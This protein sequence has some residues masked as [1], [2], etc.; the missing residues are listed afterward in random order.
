MSLGELQKHDPL[1]VVK[2]VGTSEVSHTF[3]ENIRGFM[4]KPEEYQDI[5]VAWVATE[6]AASGDYFLL[7]PNEAYWHDH[8]FMGAGPF[9]VYLLAPNA[10]GGT[11]RVA[12]EEWK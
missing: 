12:I 6:T 9:T 3:R 1:I 8:T 7:K 4:L 5:R 10:G 11:T 2:D